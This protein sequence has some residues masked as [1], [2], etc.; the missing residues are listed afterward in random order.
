MST[1]LSRP[2]ADRISRLKSVALPPEQKQIPSGAV[3]G[4]IQALADGKT[5]YT[6]RPGIVP[7]REKVSE[8]LKQDYQLDISLD[9]ITITCGIQEAEFVALKKLAPPNSQVL[10]AEDED[11]SIADYLQGFVPLLEFTLTT[12]P[13][14]P[15][16][17]RVLYIGT[18]SPHLADWLQIAVTHNW[19]V[20]WNTTSYDAS[21]FISQDN[22]LKART[23]LTGTFET[24]LPGW[25]VGWMAGSEMAGQ[26]RSYKQ[27]MTICSPSI[28]QWAAYGMINNNAE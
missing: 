14:N 12:T 19:W 8:Q 27:S 25:A 28:S 22:Q 13:D 3:D 18:S 16:E 21:A 11:G 17:I 10:Y 4:A 23:V 24:E 9:D 26:L 2:L 20:I 1:T 7:L 5:H 15:D 6:T